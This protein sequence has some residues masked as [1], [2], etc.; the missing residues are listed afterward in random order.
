MVMMM[1][2]CATT[3]DDDDDDDDDDG[4]DDDNNDDDDNDDD[5]I[6]CVYVLYTL[7]VYEYTYIL[8]TVSNLYHSLCLSRMK[9]LYLL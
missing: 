1:L 3:F 2:S 9:L 5:C 7:H 6:I 4:D 8:I